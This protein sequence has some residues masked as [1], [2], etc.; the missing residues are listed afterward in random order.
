[1]RS[2]TL[3]QIRIDI[4]LLSAIIGSLPC[5][6]C[7]SLHYTEVTPQASSERDELP[8]NNHILEDL[9]YQCR[10]YSAN[11][12]RALA[13][14]SRITRLCIAAQCDNPSDDYYYTSYPRSVS[15]EPSV[16]NVTKWP[17]FGDLKICE[18][19]I[20]PGAYL[21]LLDSILPSPTIYRLTALTFNTYS[22]I[23]HL[24]R[25]N[26]L[27]QVVGPT[28][29]CLS[30]IAEHHWHDSS[31]EAESSTVQGSWVIPCID[32]DSGFWK[33]ELFVYHRYRCH[34]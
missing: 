10:D 25:L 9:S 11:F 6:S 30:L 16:Q 22:D 26:E 2:L 21:G 23:E 15:P 3:G 8:R 33:T 24:S 20:G 4:G 28:L 17:P 12:F 7:I 5:L 27:L 32:S 34:G 14:F 19:N 29:K 1:M 13:L 18:L 31:W